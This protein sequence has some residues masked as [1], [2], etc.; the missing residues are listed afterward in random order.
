M[1]MWDLFGVSPVIVSTY[2]MIYGRLAAA[3]F[4]HPDGVVFLDSGYGHWANTGNPAH[5]VEGV[6]EWE[7]A[8]NRWEVGE[9]HFRRMT[10]DDLTFQASWQEWLD[11]CQG[12]NER[13]LDRGYMEK[14]L[15]EYGYLPE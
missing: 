6:P 11:Y 4:E 14:K 13:L 8:F 9:F 10:D 2:E 15:K 7:P 12:D 5:L 1:E 3:V